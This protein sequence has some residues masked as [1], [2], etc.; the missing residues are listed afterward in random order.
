MTKNK[1]IIKSKKSENEFYVNPAEMWDNIRDYYADDKI[2]PNAVAKN[3]HDIAEKISFMGCFINYSWRHEM[4]G[5]AKLKMMEALVGKK[6][7]LWKDEVFLDSDDIVVN[8]GE[9]MVRI[10]GEWRK[11]DKTEKL[12]GN[13]LIDKNN[14]FSYYTRIA[15]HAFLNRLKKEKKA[16]ETIDAYQEKVWEEYLSSGNGWENVRRPKFIEGDEN[17]DSGE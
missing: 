15:Y 12:I 10:S 1:S 3:I 7:K 16:K 4:I 17:D 11:L 8:D 2:V 14:A 9:T 5:D 13:K 6:F